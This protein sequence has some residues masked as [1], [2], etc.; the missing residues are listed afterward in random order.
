MSVRQRTISVEEADIVEF[1]ILH[2]TTYRYPGKIHESYSI[3][4]LRPRSD[5]SQYCTKYELN[6][7][8]RAR[9]FS[10][11]DRFGNDV[12]HFAVLPDHDVLSIIARSSVITVRPANPGAP[13]PVTKD[14]LA[15]DSNVRWLYDELHESQYV[16]FGPELRAFA[17]EVGDPGRDDLVAWYLHAGTSIKQKFTYDTK[18]TSVQT[19]IDESIRVRAGVC[20]DY[21]HILVALCR[22]YGVPARY[23]SGYIFSGEEGSVLGAEASHAWCEAY[24]GPHGW[25]GYDPTND[26]L[27]DDRFARIAVGRDYRDVSPVRGVYKGASRSSMS[28]NVAMEALAGTQQQQQQQ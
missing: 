5:S 22:F 2:Q 1:T 25:I 3:V 23:V 26:T 20:Q 16:V 9:I 4:R 15:G 13:S 7:A 19:T 14:Q 8:P 21:A 18:A 6:V 11:S 28:V 10:Y 12:Q 17:S 24:L 27:I